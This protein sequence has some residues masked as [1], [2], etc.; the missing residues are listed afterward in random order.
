M[1]RT[2]N[3]VLVVIALLACSPAFA[4]EGMRHSLG[5]YG[6][7]VGLK[8]TIGVADIAEQPVD[9]T[10]DDLANHIDFALADV[11]SP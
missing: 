3:M 2:R 9:A 4:G 6:W 8:G 7:F 1:F 5:L 10:F 11:V